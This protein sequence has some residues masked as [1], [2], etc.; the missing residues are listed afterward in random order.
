MIIDLLKKEI[1]I[2]TILYLSFFLLGMRTA[3]FFE[4]PCSPSP[5]AVAEKSVKFVKMAI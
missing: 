2:K 4:W 1:R 5:Y 3:M